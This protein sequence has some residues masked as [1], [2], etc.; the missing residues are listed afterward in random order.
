MR[1][2]EV[3]EAT[4]ALASPAPISLDSV[5]GGS[6]PRPGHPVLD[7]LSD[8]GASEDTDE[9]V[10]GYLDKAVASCTPVG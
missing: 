1:T 2:Q 6:P 5:S 4:M 7:M 3:R 9:P 8:E 10:F